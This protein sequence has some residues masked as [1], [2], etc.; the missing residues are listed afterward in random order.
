MFHYKSH[1]DLQI[2]TQQN[3]TDRIDLLEG[4]GTGI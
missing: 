4:A 1:N 2:N 3:D